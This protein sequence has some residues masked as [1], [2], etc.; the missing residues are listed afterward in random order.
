[1]SILTDTAYV[2]SSYCSGWAGCLKQRV[3]KEP[4]YAPVLFTMVSGENKD[5]E[6]ASGPRKAHTESKESDSIGSSQATK[7]VPVAPTYCTGSVVFLNGFPGVGKLTIGRA[8]KKHLPS[9]RLLDSHLLIDPA[10]AIEPNRTATFFEIRKLFLRT[11][12]QGMSMVPARDINF[13]FTSAYWDI[14]SGVDLFCE[15]LQLSRRRN[16]P[17]AF[18]NL[19]CDREE[20]LQRVPSKERVDGLKTK[21][22]DKTIL[23]DIRKSFR[24]LNPNDYPETW[25]GVSLRFTELDVTRMIP[26]NSPRAVIDFVTSIVPN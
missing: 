25:K 18:I 16:M 10:E 6:N 15:L 13:V 23:A 20:N 24:L 11:A 3:L 19:L 21:L 26:G 7:G 4:W 9:T 17:F 2:C 5:T 8:I 14:P 22:T 1:M 12:I